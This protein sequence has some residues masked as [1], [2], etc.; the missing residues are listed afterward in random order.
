MSW[1]EEYKGK[2]ISADQAAGL[3]QSGDNVTIPIASDPLALMTA[4]IARKLELKGVDVLVSVP[5]R[6]FP[7]YEPGWDDSF[8]IKYFYPSPIPEL[9]R[10]LGEGKTGDY[11]VTPSSRPT[12]RGA[13]KEGKRGGQHIVMVEISTPDEHG[14]CSFGAVV[15]DRKERIQEADIAIAEVRE[16]VMR[17]YG[18][19]SIH[20]SEIDYF[21]KSTYPPAP[22]F[23]PYEPEAHVRPIAKYVSSLINDG[24]TLQIGAGKTSETLPLVGLFDGKRD[25]GWHTERVPR[26]ALRLIKDQ[27]EVFSG[28]RKTLHPGKIVATAL[29]PVDEDDWNFV[30]MNPL[31]ELY[32]GS[33]VNDI[34]TI[35]ANDNLVAINNALCVDLTGQITAETIGSRLWS[36][37]GGQTEYPIGAMLSKGGRSITVLPA[38]AQGDSVS[39]IVPMLEPGAAVTVLRC[40]ADYVVTEYGI[41]SLRQKS[42]RERALELTNIAH[43]DYRSELRSAA[44]K[45]FWP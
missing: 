2:M 3:V 27:P 28:K 14:Y 30:H 26:G 12:P 20:V 19:N 11:V 22:I 6:E 5:V 17:T 29:A 15:W 43:P 34:R 7:W 16:N 42:Q 24:D 18:D 40:F 13:S 37:A 36:G 21:V 45:L 32:A 39:R 41:A 23:H 25:L 38:T 35:A 31:F 33:Y 4:L 44:K 8:S 9:R 10:R 1:R